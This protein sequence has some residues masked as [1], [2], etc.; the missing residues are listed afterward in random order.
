MNA[1]SWPSNHLADVHGVDDI[2]DGLTPA[3]TSQLLSRVGQKLI[4]GVYRRASPNHVLN[5]QPATC[6]VV[7]FAGLPLMAASTAALAS[8]RL[9]L[10]LLE[11]KRPTVRSTALNLGSSESPG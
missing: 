5:L 8:S 11:R 10:R 9:A 2:D 3:R 6:A 1:T 4:K 7:S